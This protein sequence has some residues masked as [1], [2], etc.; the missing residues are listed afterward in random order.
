[1]I[2]LIYLL[3]TALFMIYQLANG[4]I[5]ELSVET[6]L[7]MSDED[8]HSLSALGYGESVEDPFFASAL[9]SREAWTI[10]EEIDNE[11]E[12]ELPDIPLSERFFD[13]D[14]K[15]EDIEE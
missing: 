4:R 8:L 11:T 10:D 12:L 1:M 7:D 9:D 5:I 15:R 14:F 6:Y 2:I 3:Y 13:E